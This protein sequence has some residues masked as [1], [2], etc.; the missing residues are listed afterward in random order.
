MIVCRTRKDVELAFEHLKIIMIKLKLTL[1]PQK[2]KILDVE[3]ES[4]DF[5]GFCY[6]KFGKTKRGRK[7]PY[8][9]P[10]RKAMKKVK[11]AMRVITCRKS[12]YEGLEQKVE[13]LNLLI[14]GWRNYFQHGNSTKQFKQLDEYVWMKL[15]RRVYYNLKLT[16]AAVLAEAMLTFKSI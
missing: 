5:F 16:G 6:Q 8:M 13:K 4:F 3:R 7:L 12:A 11:D 2:T 1:N 10:S 14:R 15:W 9:M